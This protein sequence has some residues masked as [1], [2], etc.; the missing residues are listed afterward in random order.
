[1]PPKTSRRREASTLL[2]WLYE[3]GEDALSQVLEELFGDDTASNR[4]EKTVRGAADAKRRVDRNMQFLLSLLNLPSRSDY[5]KL[6]AKIEALQG[7]LLNIN[8]KLDRLL[9]AETERRSVIRPAPSAPGPR[10]RTARG[11][12]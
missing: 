2:A 5:N 7:S 1:M 8:M 12:G 4:L 6:L 11:E 3:R 9:A 10:K